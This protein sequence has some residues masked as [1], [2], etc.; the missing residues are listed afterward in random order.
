MRMDN[1][2]PK[3]ISALEMYSTILPPSIKV[4]PS[5]PHQEIFFSTQ[6]N[7]YPPLS[8][9]ISNY[10]QKFPNFAPKLFF[11]TNSGIE[12]LIRG[13]ATQLQSEVDINFVD[14]IRN[15]LFGPP[16]S[17]GFDLIALNTNRGRDHVRYHKYFTSNFVKGIPLYNDL[18]S[19]YGLPRYQQFSQVSTDA[20]V[21]E[22]LTEAY[23][24][25]IDA[26][27][28][29]VCGLAEGN[30]SYIISKTLRPC[31]KCKCWSHLSSSYFGS[32]QESS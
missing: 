25:N 27:D 13:M 5:L 4:I 20:Y 24:G 16:G 32:I 12:P 21:V 19:L 10:P 31:H 29:Y 26:C 30:H 18:R 7:F 11:L 17:G 6:K 2:S 23:N 22:K 28:L 1:R 15:F 8:E 3:V 9:K 14:D